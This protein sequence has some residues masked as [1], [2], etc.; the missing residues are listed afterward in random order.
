MILYWYNND[1]ESGQ[2]ANGNSVVSSVN[3]LLLDLNDN[4]LNAITGSFYLKANVEILN[5]IT[6]IQQ[7]LIIIQDCII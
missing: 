5:I 7:N 4:S 3:D 2:I 1:I 6:N